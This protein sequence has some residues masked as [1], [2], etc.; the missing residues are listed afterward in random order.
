[1]R[2]ENRHFARLKTKPQPALEQRSAH[3]AGAD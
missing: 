2:L 1:L 3:L